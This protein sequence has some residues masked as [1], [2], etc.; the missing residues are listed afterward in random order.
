MLRS[1]TPKQ[2]HV[3]SCGSSMHYLVEGWCNLAWHQTYQLVNW[4]TW[5]KTKKILKTYLVSNKKTNQ[6]QN[7]SNTKRFDTF[8]TTQTPNPFPTKNR[9]TGH[10]VGNHDEERHKELRQSHLA[11]VGWWCSPEKSTTGEFWHPIGRTS[12]QTVNKQVWPNPI[13][14]FWHPSL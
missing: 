14:E 10:P 1:L 9:P 7:Q 3:E 12:K 13:G 8:C 6:T 11:S 2:T 5:S 4:D